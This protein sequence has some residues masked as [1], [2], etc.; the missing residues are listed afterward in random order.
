MILIAVLAAGASSASAATAQAS[1]HKKRAANSVVR[2]PAHSSP[3]TSSH[4]AKASPK[5]APKSTAKSP[6]VHSTA[7]KP[8]VGRKSH[9]K[10]KRVKGQ[11]AP[12]STRISEIQEALARQGSF[13]GTP[14]GV[15]DDDT[16]DAMRKF[17]STHGLRPSGKLDAPTLQKLGLGSETAG[18]APPMPP[19]NSANRLM[20]TTSAPEPR[21]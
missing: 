19:P 9:R 1:A 5:A 21:E 13:S 15:W 16:V 14:S 2:H 20:N 10:A 12:T 11:A 17:Q 6:A 3:R 7:G 18:L 4:A 8:V